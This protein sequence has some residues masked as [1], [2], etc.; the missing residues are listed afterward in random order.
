MKGCLLRQG[1]TPS[2]FLYHA[3]ATNY[4]YNHLPPVY[5]GMSLLLPLQRLAAELVSRVEWFWLFKLE[6]TF[7]ISSQR[8]LKFH[9]LPDQ[10]LRFFRWTPSDSASNSCIFLD[11]SQGYVNRGNPFLEVHW[12]QHHE[13]HT[14]WWVYPHHILEEYS[15]SSS[16]S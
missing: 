5:W 15:P 8:G 9:C 2:P 16:H 12:L 4:Q 6:N 13:H 14:G 11:K 3:W 7:G 10:S 1:L